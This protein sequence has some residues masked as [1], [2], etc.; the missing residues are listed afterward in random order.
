MYLGNKYGS[1]KA[2]DMNPVVY[3]M[4]YHSAKGLDF[5]Y[6][7]IPFLSETKTFVHD[8]A[9]LGSPGLGRRLLFVAVT[10]SRENLYLSY[11]GPKCH[12]YLS[13]L[14]IEGVSRSKLSQIKYQ[15]TNKSNDEDF[16]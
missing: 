16:F 1:L 14:P 8:T 13:N 3:L 4:T 15:H 5:K 12:P 9:L 7:F 6:V 2:S 11:S 10:R